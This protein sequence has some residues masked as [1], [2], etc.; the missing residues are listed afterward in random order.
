[1]KD[2]LLLFLLGK[3]AQVFRL[4]III[5]TIIIPRTVRN[6]KRRRNFFFLVKDGMNAGD[7]AMRNKSSQ[8]VCVCPRVP[9]FF[10]DPGLA[11]LLGQDEVV[12]IER[13]KETS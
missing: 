6:K 2:K 10:C 8:F 7:A 5:I 3:R 9:D 4:A 11:R 12:Y 1:M 13:K